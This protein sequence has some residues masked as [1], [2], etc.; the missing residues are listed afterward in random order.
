MHTKEDKLKEI[1]TPLIFQ[2]SW[3]W[4]REDGNRKRKPL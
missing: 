1:Y 4:C 2:T 3:L